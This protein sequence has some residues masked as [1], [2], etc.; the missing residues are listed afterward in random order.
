MYHKYAPTHR[1]KHMSSCTTAFDKA[2]VVFSFMIAA[3]V[4][5]NKEAAFYQLAIQTAWMLPFMSFIY[6]QFVHWQ[7]L[8]N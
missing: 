3:M 2:F 5:V 7:C 1:E 4:K 8:I 6:M